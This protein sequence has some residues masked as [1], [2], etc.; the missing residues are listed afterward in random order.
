MANYVERMSRV[1]RPQSRAAAWSRRLSVFCLPYLLIVVL[2]HRFGAVDTIS[3]FWLLGLAVLLLI[4]AIAASCIG[5]YELWTY[6]HKG[7]LSSARGLLLAIVLLLPFLYY[8]G[9]ALT[10]PQLYDI[11]TDLDDA[12]TY[13]SVLE[14]RLEIMNPIVDPTDIQKSL[15][16]KAY[17]RVAAR[18]YP[19]DTGQ[20]F[21]EVVA[22]IS[23]RD[24]TILTVESEPGQAPIDSEGSA[25][26]ARPVVDSDGRPLRFPI[27]ETRP[28]VRPDPQAFETI[29]VSPIGRE[30][31]TELEE[32]E[33]RYVEAVAMSFLFGFESDVVI[34]LVEEEEGTLV[35]MRSS[36]RWGAHDL[37]SNAARIISFM[38]DLDESL[39]GLRR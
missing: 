23:E 38:Q 24:W 7:G 34:R 36:S 15:Q 6:G 35:D 2:G 31:E 12:P 17:P 3:T 14:D 18:R 19:L 39:Q 37:G 4:G 20:V 9:K 10:L 11:S 22:L 27:P 16:I 33:E 28:V 5:F 25:L 26:V 32:Q 29:Q 1:V 8:A 13:D 21:R 30:E